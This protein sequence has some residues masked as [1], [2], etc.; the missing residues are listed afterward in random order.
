MKQLYKK[1]THNLSFITP[2][3]YIKFTFTGNDRIH[4][5]QLIG[6][7]TWLAFYVT[8]R[9][10]CLSRVHEFNN[11]VLI[12]PI[13]AFIKSRPIM[14]RTFNY[15]NNLAYNSCVLQRTNSNQ[16]NDLGFFFHLLTKYCFFILIQRS[17]KDTKNS[18]ANNA[19]VLTKTIVQV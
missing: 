19:A 4:Q 15:P 14:K 2:K 8:S 7:R 6:S 5:C 1:K 13:I 3:T 11:I 16:Y 12:A 10:R 18:L 9:V 17:V